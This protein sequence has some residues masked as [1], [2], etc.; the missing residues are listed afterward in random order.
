MPALNPQLHELT[1]A[2]M[3]VVQRHDWHQEG[4]R[5]QTPPW[6]LQDGHAPSPHCPCTPLDPLMMCTPHVQDSGVGQTRFVGLRGHAD[7]HR[8]LM[9]IC[10]YLVNA[11]LYVMP[12]PCSSPLPT[13]S[14]LIC[15][16][17]AA[18]I[19]GVM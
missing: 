12:H 19:A 18:V 6:A 7:V 9:V 1:A 17:G 10:V 2:N 5:R 4:S 8:Q 14:L 15:R 11:V 16:G 13:C 3:L